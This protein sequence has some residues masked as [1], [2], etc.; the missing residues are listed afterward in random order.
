MMTPTGKPLRDCTGSECRQ[1]G[2][3]YLQIA[4]RVKPKQRVSAVLQEIDVRKL[5]QE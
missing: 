5:Y 3:W 4:E 2:G 1:M